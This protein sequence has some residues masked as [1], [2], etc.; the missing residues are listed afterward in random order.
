MI[1]ITLDLHHTLLWD[2][3]SDNSLDMDAIGNTFIFTCVYQVNDKKTTKNKRE[4]KRVRMRNNRIVIILQTSFVGS[5]KDEY[6]QL[7]DEQI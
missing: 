1:K 3:L 2:N 5:D 4:R 6:E 7:D